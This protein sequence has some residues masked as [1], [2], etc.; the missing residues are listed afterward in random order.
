[1]QLLECL[2]MP[3]GQ[4]PA[5]RLTDG[6]EENVERTRC[7]QTWIELTQAAGRRVAR[8]DERPLPLRER[9]LVHRLEAGDRHEDFA[10]HL[11]QLRRLTAKLDGHRLDRAHVVRHVFSSRTVASRGSEHETTS[12]VAKAHRQAVELRLS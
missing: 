4:R 1:P 2:R 11:E 8:I 10:A 7:G 9:A 3:S 6:I 5:A 12:F